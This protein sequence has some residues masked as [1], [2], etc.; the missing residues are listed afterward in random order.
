MFKKFINIVI[1]AGLA[2]FTWF[3]NIYYQ[4]LDLTKITYSL[5]G[6]AVSYG[7]FKLMLEEGVAKQIKESKTR[8][9]F[10]KTTSILFIAISFIIVLRIWIINP[11]A[12]LVAYGLFA[13]GVAISLQ[14][15]FKNFAGGL[16]IFIT[17]VYR[18]GDRI[19]VNSK[20]GDV[21]D[22]GLFYTTLLEIGEWVGGDQA[23]GRIIML[24]NGSVLSAPINNYSK[25]H[26][27]IWDELS[28]PITY[29]SNWKKAVKDIEKI[30]KKETLEAAE[31]AERGI[32]ELTEKYFFPNAILTRWSSFN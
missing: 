16:A 11:Q 31:V 29:D 7:I 18:V 17:S 15:V 2:G 9:S 14:D 21:I 1:L 20:R 32:Y 13:A 19:E 30:V 12:L 23:T 25:D 10:R 4:T 24:P 8:Y 28:I 6:I 26:H 27:F 3:I 5:I 22:I